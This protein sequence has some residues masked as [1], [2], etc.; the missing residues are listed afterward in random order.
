MKPAE[1]GILVLDF[2][3]QYAHLIVRRV[4]ELEVPCQLVPFSIPTSQVRESGARGLI[5]S[6]GPAS[7]YAKGAPK[8][9]PDAL[10]LG[11][12]ILGICYGHQLISY[13]FGGAVAPAEKC[14]YGES[15][16][17]TRAGSA[18]FQ[19]IPSRSRIWASHGDQV[20]KMPRGFQVTATSD[21]SLFA[22]IEDRRRRIFGLQFHPEVSQTEFG[23][24]MLAAF[25]YGVCGCRKS[26]RLEDF[27]STEIE[28]IRRKVGGDRVLC[29]VSGGVDSSTLA[30]LISKAVGD[31]LTCL[32]VDHGL[33]RKGEGEE[34]LHALRDLLGLNVVRVDA[35]GRFLRALKGVAD[36]E[37]KRLIVGAEF[38]NVFE[39]FSRKEG[40]FEWLAQGTLYPDVIES[41][42]TAGPASRIKA[43][44]NVAGLPKGVPFKLLEPLRDLYKDE[45]RKIAAKLG[46]PHEFLMRHPFPGPG[47]AVRVIGEV[48]PEK[49]KVCR[50]ADAAFAEE[51]RSAGLYEGLW[52]AFAVVGDDK[53]VGVTGD[54]RRYGYLVTLKAV[55]SEDGMTADWAR[56]PVELLDSVSRKVTNRLPE[57][58]M[59]AY[60]ITN[61]PPS[62]IEPQ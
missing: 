37:R 32:F 36:P 21:N 20:T 13:L 34:V 49:L 12:P 10:T 57:V 1:G 52:Q 62:T 7:V 41:A 47:L 33:L 40:P 6:G 8:P 46:M 35:S 27:V 56:L 60:A 5:F 11:L 29:A 54:S 61:K 30:L 3:G 55:T 14:E 15:T 18:L 19:K 22:A 43:H 39:E 38:A 23:K 26:W 31:Q 24:E 51:L 44:H 45:V 50:E 17:K 16:L 2:G 53:V 4:R 28:E 42:S 48:T 25:V 59:V 58:S 9:S